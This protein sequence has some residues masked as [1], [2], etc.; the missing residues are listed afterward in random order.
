MDSKLNHLEDSL[1]KI[2]LKELR[3]EYKHLFLDV[4]QETNKIFHDMDV[5][6]AKP[7]KRHPYRS[8]PVKQQILKEE[9]QY[10]L[11]N[12]FIES[13]PCILVPK[14]DGSFRMCTDYRKVNNCTKTDTF[15]ITT[16]DVRQNWTDK[17]RLQV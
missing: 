8:N 16:I 17:I 10:L 13:S 4:Q 6:D 9:I 11:E 3:Y 2:E 15:P 12:Y 1:K 14:A 5:G 7:I